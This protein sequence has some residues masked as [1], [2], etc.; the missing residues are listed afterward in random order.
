MNRLL[1]T[2]LCSIFFFTLLLSSKYENLLLVEFDNI[3]KN[4]KFDYLRHS[5]PDIIKN[6]PN[7]ENIHIE[8]AGKIEPFLDNSYNYL[9]S[10]ILLV[11]EYTINNDAI[12]ISYGFFDLE[13]WNKIYSETIVYPLNNIDSIGTIL[14]KSFS[15]GLDIVIN[16]EVVLEMIDN[17]ID[18]NIL[19]ESNT[20]ENI[21]NALDDFAIE[22][23]LNYSWDEINKDGKQYGTRYYKDLDEIEQNDLLLNSKENNTNKLLSYID[24]ILL[25]PY[26][27]TIGTISV[28]YSDPN[29]EFV[30][31]NI[32]VSYS[33]KN[34]LI[35]DLLRTLPSETTS[36][37]DGIISIKFD[38]ENF[39][40]SNQTIDR[41]SLIKYQVVPVLFLSNTSKQLKNI[42]ID[43]WS[44]FSDS[45]HLALDKSTMITSKEFYPLFSIIPGKNNLQIILDMEQI[46]ILYTLK[47]SADNVQEYSK[48]AIKF[49]MESDINKLFENY[50]YNNE[51]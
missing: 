25:N 12:N 7:V 16:E 5:I 20:F 33:I 30:N 13:S 3:N 27:V 41:F 35:E 39:I 8:Y 42:F 46:D 2:Y 21:Y 17:E 47:V 18:M 49:L 4:K 9:N 11:G 24:K 26:D 44:S 31:I 1:K 14:D 51:N 50:S 34:N 22:V 29:Q 10:T 38:K 36:N 37:K 23:D 15:K 32:P 40:F 45:N 48:I 6:I 43:H 19:S 28:G